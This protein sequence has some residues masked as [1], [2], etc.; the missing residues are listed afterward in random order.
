MLA[1]LQRRSG[2]RSSVFDIVNS[3]EMG[4]RER[5][6]ERKGEVKSRHEGPFSLPHL[7]GSDRSFIS[8]EIA[9]LELL[10]PQFKD[11]SSKSS[12]R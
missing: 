12:G 6:R 8:K 5:E 1:G 4:E 9:H 3:G 11:P 2:L 7:Q 10:S